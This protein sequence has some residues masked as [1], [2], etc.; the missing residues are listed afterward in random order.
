MQNFTVDE[1]QYEEGYDEAG[2]DAWSNKL[3]VNHFKRAA[4]FSN[5]SPLLNFNHSS[6]LIIIFFIKSSYKNGYT[7]EQLINHYL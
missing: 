2:M 7:A 6:T 3:V 5:I 4:N 1:A